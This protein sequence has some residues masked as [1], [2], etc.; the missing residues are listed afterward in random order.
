MFADGEQ[1][2]LGSVPVPPPSEP[3]PTGE[4]VPVPDIA[5][6]LAAPAHKEEAP[7]Q[8]PAAFGGEGEEEQ[9]A[10]KD[11]PEAPAAAAP[12]T[13]VPSATEPVPMELAEATE[14]GVAFHKGEVVAIACPPPEAF[15]LGIAR[16]DIL[17]IDAE[18]RAKLEAQERAQ[19][20]PGTAAPTPS[21]VGCGGV[22]VSDGRVWVPIRWLERVA[23][24]ES[25]DDLYQ[26]GRYE[27]VRRSTV[28]G[29]AHVAPAEADAPAGARGDAQ[30]VLAMAERHRLVRLIANGAADARADADSG[31]VVDGARVLAIVSRATVKDTAFFLVKWGGFANAAMTWEPMNLLAESCPDLVAHFE[32][33]P[34]KLA[35]QFPEPQ[36]Q[37]IPD[38]PLAPDGTPLL[39]PGASP[40]PGTAPLLPPGASPVPTPGASP[41]PAGRTLRGRQGGRTSTRGRGGAR[42]ARA[43]SSGS[44]GAGE[45]SPS[46]LAAAAP[47]AGASPLG[48]PAAPFFGTPATLTDASAGPVSL[49]SLPHMHGAATTTPASPMLP[50][51]PAGPTGIPPSPLPPQ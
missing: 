32:E 18:T 42:G 37:A 5:A 14:P 29:V 23:S 13:A 48:A 45:R 28:L 35:I 1:S 9:P 16:A 44:A 39:P 12:T 3:V 27:H 41:A 11:E 31:D 40:I 24:Y 21:G 7:Q 26:Q 6:P 4:S 43:S 36:P 20:A 33:A 34:Y 49:A 19:A 51:T 15:W 50:G 46:P 8:A 38:Q 17:E 47:G 30:F 25:G 10:M 2:A 22:D